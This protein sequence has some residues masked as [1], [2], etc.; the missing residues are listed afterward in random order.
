MLLEGDKRIAY[1]CMPITTLLF[2][3]CF[4]SLIPFFFL[5]K[6]FCSNFHSLSCFLFSLFS[7]VPSCS[8]MFC[9]YVVVSPH[10]AWLRPFLYL[11]PWRVFTILPLNRFCPSM[12]V[13]PRPPTSLSATQ[14]SPFTCA[15]RAYPIPR[16]NSIILFACSLWHSHPDKGG[17]F[18]S[19][20]LMACT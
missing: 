12:G 13:F 14:S 10:C 2:T 16:Q 7:L 18:L 9:G 19:L 20:S 1:W 5:S 8:L 15:G 4:F 3:F 17:H 11:L 6:F